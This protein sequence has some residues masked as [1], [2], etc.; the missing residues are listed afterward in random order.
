MSMPYDG[1]A[2]Q[3]VIGSVLID[4]NELTSVR[5]IIAP[6]DFYAERNRVLYRHVLKVTEAGL[7]ADENLLL[8]SLRAS[9]ELEAIGGSAYLMEVMTSVPMSVYAEHYARLV[10]K[11]A[12]MRRTIQ[13]AQEIQAL[14]QNAEL[15]PDELHAR[16]L[17]VL[18]KAAPAS[19][20]KGRTLSEGLQAQFDRAKQRARG[21][22]PEGSISSGLKD[23]DELITGLEPG[24]LYLLAARPALGKSAL[25]LSI[26]LRAAR[27]GE[28]VIYYSLEMP[29][30][31]LGVRAACQ[32]AKIDATRFT[33]G[34]MSPGEE[35][36]FWRAKAALEK[37]PLVVDEGADL[38]VEGLRASSRQYAG[39][40][41]AGLI[42]VDY[43]QLMEGRTGQ[44]GTTREQEVSTISRNLKRLA[45]GMNCPVLALSQL[46]RNLESRE[47]KRPT[48]ADLRE[49]G[50]LEQ[51]ADVV[52]FIYRD[53]VYDK[54]SQEKGVAELIV[55]KQR[56]GPIGTAKV[57][58]HSQYVSFYDLDYVQRREVAA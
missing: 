46:N 29:A 14:G 8:E 18:A 36:A 52:T 55:G 15:T 27:S 28:L 43:L 47:N 35:A 25:A 49:S 37:F 10:Q 50:S 22:R 31:E 26:A 56:G 48:L 42:V 53:E 57:Q 30:D 58:W 11:Y 33:H 7:P 40:R 6:E 16:A 51:D 9:N 24:K 20:R 4:H 54:Q 3:S 45:R 23:Y 12:T 41:R 44:K 21:E 32:L 19:A 2:E 1:D 13:A 38:T 17:E 34:R 39:S 5:A